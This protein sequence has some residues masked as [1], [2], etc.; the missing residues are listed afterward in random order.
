MTRA[1]PSAGEPTRPI[2]V[3]AAEEVGLSFGY[4]QVV[5]IARRV[6]DDPEPHGEHC[7]TWGVDPANSGVAA[8]IGDLLTRRVMGWVADGI[9]LEE[10]DIDAG[11]RRL[12]AAIAALDEALPLLAAAARNL[13]DSDCLY[14][15]A[16]G[17]P[18]PGTLRETR[19][20]VEQLLGAIRKAEACAGQDWRRAGGINRWLLELVDRRRPL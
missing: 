2:P 1:T 10:D 6:G 9:L 15:R 16:T 5:I 20:A 8:A 7:T 19:P 18:L 3:R 13:I 4:D 12:I 17:A 11:S 14:D